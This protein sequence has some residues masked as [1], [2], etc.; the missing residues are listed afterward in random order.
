MGI[1]L[2]TVVP[3][4]LSAVA[5]AIVAARKGRSPMGWASLGLIFPIVAVVVV[6][7]LRPGAG[8]KTAIG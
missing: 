2:W 1:A 8:R 5:C 7:L 6:A 3:A 4:V